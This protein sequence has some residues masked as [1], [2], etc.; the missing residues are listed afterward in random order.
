[1]WNEYDEMNV[2]IYYET[3]EVKYRVAHRTFAI[4]CNVMYV[5]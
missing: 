3:K 5:M 1:M 4:V 2:S